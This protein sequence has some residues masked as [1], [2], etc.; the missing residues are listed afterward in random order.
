MYRLRHT[1]RAF[2]HRAFRRFYA[3]QSISV[4][5]SWIQTI[6][7]SWLVYRL[8]SSPTLLGLTTFLTQAPILLIGSV[9][10]TFGDRFDR[11]RLLLVA[12]ALLACQALVLG[13]MTLA[14][15]S[16]I[17]G[18]L[19][20]ALVQ[21]LI[22]SVETPVRQSFLAVLVPEREDLPNAVALNS[23]LMNSGRLFGP[24]I[25]GL[26]LSL[27]SEGVCFLI[28]AFSFLAV[29]AAVAV[30]DS[31]SVTPNVRASSAAH[32]AW[33]EGLRYASGHPV[34]RTLLPV[35]AIVSFFGSPYVTLMPAVVGE[36]FGGDARTLGWLVSSAGLGGI[37]GTAYLASHPRVQAL[38]MVTVFACVMLGSSLV[39]FSVSHALWFCVLMM[40]GI[41]FGVIAAAASVNMLIQFGT[42]DHIRGRMIGLYITSF[43]GVAPL[44]ALAAGIAAQHIGTRHTLAVG[45]VVCILTALLLRRRLPALLAQTRD[46]HL[47]DQASGR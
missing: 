21:G 7:L 4:I 17:R 18:Y 9:A 32:N 10:G 40:P 14:G 46:D 39:A 35:V 8:T 23:F 34:I 42:P 44:G 28:N 36:S 20:I 30:T 6:A 45:G 1:T 2:R 24:A 47:P 22:A 41:G 33:R 38:P 19:A 15:V 11:K 12:E 13:A 3:G 27:T 16:D 31:P 29:M 43:L 26:L 25:A 37:A 5:G